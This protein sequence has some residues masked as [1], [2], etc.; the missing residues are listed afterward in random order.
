M[1]KTKRSIQYTHH[2]PLS[3][4]GRICQIGALVFCFLLGLAMIANVQLG[5]EAMWFWYTVL[6][7]G[8][9]RLYRDLYLPLQPLYVLEMNIWMSL[10]GRKLLT[11]E[12]PAVFHLLALLSGIFLV[13]RQSAWPG[14]Q[15]AIVLVAAFVLCV[16]GGSYR[17]D[18]YH[19]TTE[20][21]IFYSIFLL[22]VLPRVTSAQRQFALDAA[23]GVLSG[24]TVM[25]RL[26][27]GGALIGAVVVAVLCIA[28]RR[29]LLTLL[30]YLAVLALT[31][32]LVLKL[33]G[34]SLSDYLSN[35]LIKAV[36]SKGGSG[37]VLTAPFV[38]VR[39]TF[40]DVR[41]DGKRVFAWLV[42]TAGLGALVYRRWKLSAASIISIQLA[43]TVVYYA[44]AFASRQHGFQYALLE[45]HWN[46]VSMTIEVL[47]LATYLFTLIVAA[48][49]VR[50][51]ST[52]HAWDPREILILI[53]LG[54]W[55][56]IS[57]SSGGEPL[58][59]YYAPVAIFLLLVP[60]LQ[61]FR[62]YA[63]W[64][65][66]SVLT[67]L[68]LFAACGV[69]SKILVPYAWQNYKYPTMF[70]HRVWY[71]H[72]VY[73]PMYID[74]D[75]LQFSLS[76]CRDIGQPQPGS[77]PTEL[78]SLPYPFPNYFCDVKPWHG[79][80]QTFFDIST[81]ATIENMMSQLDTEPPKYV[82]YQRQMEI[83]RGAERLYNHGQPLAQ[84]ELD[85]MIF[86]KLS[87]GQWK[88][89]DKS[90]YL[91]RTPNGDDGWF[92][93]QTHP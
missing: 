79:Y 10:L 75:L 80:V 77:P 13:V 25:T 23:L 33:T 3:R 69:I 61:P 42:L 45:A 87:T 9:A 82:V 78:L 44:V 56:A 18:D 55:A 76:V 19:V 85:D 43:F 6:F 57:A 28:P 35:T 65:N 2:K 60:V 15:K 52:S 4:T 81:R 14:W 73:G 21:F 22:L 74:R 83:L 32:V 40:A 66:A 46:F 24:F 92:I 34:D 31:V 67:V 71:D 8:G 50:S 49:M 53:P 20:S 29:R 41:H 68:L 93:M 39:N 27:D 72:P 64:V 5:G 89:L 88:L 38:V 16:Q 12:I 84:H 37:S 58:T 7:H 59:S 54:G 17:F 62:R 36:G 48:R 86:R 1:K 26:N 91:N 51:C 11:T 30:L 47:L 63:A 90:S 70:E